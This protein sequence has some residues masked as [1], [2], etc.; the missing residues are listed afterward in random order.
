MKERRRKN[1][2]YKIRPVLPVF[3]RA[4]RASFLLISTL[5]SL[6]GGVEGQQLRWFIIILAE[7]EGQCQFVCDAGKARFTLRG[8]SGAGGEEGTEA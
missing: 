3:H 1:W 5:N 2:A 4:Q 8:R 6:Q 7:V